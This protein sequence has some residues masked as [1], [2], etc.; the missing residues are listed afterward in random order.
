MGPTLP[1]IPMNEKARAH[2]PGPIGKWCDLLGD[3]GDRD[4]EVNVG[5]RLGFDR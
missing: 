2:G 1:T 5:V 4:L 3:H